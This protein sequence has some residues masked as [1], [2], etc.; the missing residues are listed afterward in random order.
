MKI[1]LICIGDIP[2]FDSN[3]I[4][5]RNIYIY[6][7]IYVYISYLIASFSLFNIK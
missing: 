5:L 1:I 7:Y 6:I 2:Y 3:A 4:I